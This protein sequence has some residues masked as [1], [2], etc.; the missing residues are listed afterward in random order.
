MIEKINSYT[1]SVKNGIFQCNLDTC[2]RCMKQ[3]PGFSCH[4]R[5]R[6]TFLVVIENIVH[7]ILSIMMRCKCPLCSG[8]FTV[9]P[10]F[11]LPYKRY[12]KDFILEKSI[13][14]VEDD[15]ATYGKTSKNKHLALGYASTQKGIIDE[16]QF[17]HST[18]HRWLTW[19]STLTRTRG[20]GDP[21]PRGRGCVGRRDRA[22]P[23]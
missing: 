18:L 21:G 13:R 14:Y 11:A 23:A 16:K 8:T 20:T 10:D 1:E 12:T 6:R 9:Y 17:V 5:K 22:R 7:K 15:A 4:D 2:P 3:P 19:F